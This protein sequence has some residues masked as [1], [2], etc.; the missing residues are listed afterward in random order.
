MQNCK[1][2][3]TNCLSLL[4]AVKPCHTQDRLAKGE[5]ISYVNNLLLFITKDCDSNLF[6]DGSFKRKGEELQ[7]VML[8]QLKTACKRQQ[9]RAKVFIISS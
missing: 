2:I 4:L 5:A 6:E 3:M 9:E 1:S 8:S 7:P